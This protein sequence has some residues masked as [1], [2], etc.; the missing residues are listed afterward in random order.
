[1]RNA[2]LTASPFANAKALVP[3]SE[4]RQ[5]RRCGARLATEP[6]PHVRHHR[7]R[8]ARAPRRSGWSTA[9]SGWN[10]AAMTPPASPTRAGRPARAPPRGGQDAR[11]GGRAGATSRWRATVGIGHTRWAT[12][13]A[14]NDRN[15]HPHIAGRVAVV[16]NG[17]IENFAELKAE[18]KAEGRDVRERH[19]HRGG[20]PADRSRTWT[21]AM[22][23]LDALKAT[24]DRLHRRLC[25][26]RADR[27]RG[28]AWSWARGAAR[29][30]VVGYGEGEMF[31]GSDALAVGPFTNRVAYLEEGDYVAIDH[32][33]GAA[34]STTTGAA[35]RAAGADRRRLRRPGR[36]GQLP[37]LHG[38]GDPR[39]AG[40]LPAHPRRLCR[41][42]DRP[43]RACPGGVDFARLERIQ[44]VACGTAYYR[45]PD[46][47]VPVRAAGRPAGGRRDRLGVPLPRA[48][49]A[50]PGTLAIA[51]SQSG[52]TADT[53]AALRWCQ[54]KGLK[55]AAVVNA[56][57]VD[58]GP[59][60]RRAV[61][62]PL[63]ARRSASPRPRPSPP[64]S[65][66]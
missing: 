23:P 54:A 1:M 45:R 41:H 63:R 50:A 55:T 26:G 24:L 53:L 11:A 38:E 27:G 65:P 33:Q 5:R 13:G 31:I 66:C 62:D 32:D 10:T 6:D 25:A 39:A 7:H 14:P 59:R 15:A 64:R 51:I 29:P 56:H 47:Q 28:P 19:R 61:A 16:H 4:P 21:P 57:R 17:I 58:H 43:R 12:H 40:R 34:S 52:E 37:P 60:G 20:R 42:P 35:G 22:A 44:I 46:R 18:L 9:C 48:G 49:A 36:E 8:R 30:L 3:I 2:D